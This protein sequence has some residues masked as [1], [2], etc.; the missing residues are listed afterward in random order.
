MQSSPSWPLNRLLTRNAHSTCWTVTVLSVV[1]SLCL[2]CP[3][4][5]L[6]AEP[7]QEKPS[8]PAGVQAP[9]YAPGKYPYRLTWGANT[10]VV[11][12]EP[13]TVSDDN[14]HQPHQVRIVDA[15]GHLLCRI[16]ADQ[17]EDVRLVKPLVASEQGLLIVATGG[18]SGL[19]DFYG[20]G[21]GVANRF[22]VSGAIQI[23]VKDLNG[24]GTAEV[25]AVYRL[26]DIDGGGEHHGPM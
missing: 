3:L 10:V 14:P 6:N 4:P 19:E 13:G 16:E 26:S 9:P 21:K 1:F 11:E 5:S 22:H 18:N 15:S 25:I 2:L 8:V 23:D 7:A 24:D 17:V 12:V 20:F